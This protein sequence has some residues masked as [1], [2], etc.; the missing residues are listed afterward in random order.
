[1]AFFAVSRLKCGQLTLWPLLRL[2]GSVLVLL[3][4][5]F[6]AIYLD[7]VDVPS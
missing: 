6:V 1:M 7:L 2:L 4:S 5:L 3:T